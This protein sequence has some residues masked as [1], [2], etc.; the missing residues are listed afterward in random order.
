MVNRDQIFLNLNNNQLEFVQTK[1]I[2]VDGTK[3][4]SFE[5]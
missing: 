3:S 1:T 5:S 4:A 2:P